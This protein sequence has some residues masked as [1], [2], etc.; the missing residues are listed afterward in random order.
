MKRLSR[1][2]L[3]LTL[4]PAGGCIGDTGGGL[5]HFDAEIVGPPTATG[6]A[7]RFTTAAGYD[8]TLER[9]VLRVGAVYLND[10]V[11]LTSEREASCLRD[12]V[13]VGEVTSGVEVDLLSPTPT[14][15]PGGGSGL[16]A[17]ARVGEVWLTGSGNVNASE[18]RT[19][20]FTFAGTAARG[21]ETVRFSG[22]FTIGQN[23]KEAPSSPSQPGS[24]SICSERIVTNI[25]VDLTVRDGATLRVRVDPA[26]IFD[27]VSFAALPG[28]EGQE[29][30]FADDDSNTPSAQAY[31]GLRRLRGVYTFELE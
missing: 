3:V 27:D 6:E 13:Y 19:P 29:R 26:A 8:V 9:A 12:G 23:R 17:R 2:V 14:P 31:A 16:A 1:H 5:A 7:L 11:P 30:T 28:E 20:I 10:Q 21:G 24:S 15:F 22:R 4:L 25:P 18:D